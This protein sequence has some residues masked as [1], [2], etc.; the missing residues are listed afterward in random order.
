MA[1]ELDSVNYGFDM[2]QAELIERVSRSEAWDDTYRS[3]T[4]QMLIELYA[5]V[6]NLVLFLIERQ[7]DESYIGT[8]RKKSSIVNLVQLVGYSPKRKKSSTGTLKFTL[9]EASSKKVYIPKDTVVQTNNGIKF[10]VKEDV[11]I[12]PGETE[13]AVTAIQGERSTSIKTATG[14]ANFVV[15]I[16]SQDVEHD[17]IEVTVAGQRWS[18]V[19]FF[20]SSTAQ[21]LHYKETVTPEGVVQ[22]K[23]GGGKF[24]KIPEYGQQVV[25]K[26][27]DSKGID[28][29]V[30]QVGKINTVVSKIQ[31][32]DGQPVNISVMNMDLF[33][34]GD[35]EE[36]VE[37]IR[38][39][40][41]RV[42]KTAD[43]AVSKEDHITFLEGIGGV[44]NA[45]V[46]GEAEQEPPNLAKMNMVSMCVLMQEW[47]SPTADKK[48]EIASFL[49]TRSMETIRYE[50]IP[51]DIVD[52]IVSCDVNANQGYVLSVLEDTVINKLQ[53]LFVLGKTTKLGV[54]K[55]KSN[56]DKV[57]D[58][59]TG[60]GYV[61]LFML[62]KRGL[63]AHYDGDNYGCKL[64]LLAVKKLSLRVYK[65]D[66]LLAKDNGEGTLVSEE[67][68]H[69]AS[70][71]I[72]YESGEIK[73]TLTND[74]EEGSELHVTYE[75]DTSGDLV[76]GRNQILK[77]DQV[78]VTS[79]KYR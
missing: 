4:G 6:A 13:I 36:D 44:A 29:N 18:K 56:I 77:L 2:I 28:G 66:V 53:S 69:V 5:Y 62:I 75:Q 54:N 55:R 49:V 27:I 43:R 60:V 12:M 78:K 14:A 37:E 76:V 64:P 38:E 9:E 33:L 25:I 22:I 23:F 31:D 46:W 21:S 65:D 15:D 30:Y 32:E 8:A 48:K 39:E 40:A 59:I 50:F 1:D 70:G 72:D 11:V 45:N 57:V 51:A 41:P 52:V 3:A 16:P 79:I 19:E 26:Y 10:L 7:A 24:G 74:I 63:Q 67:T 17:S 34:G 71:T 68:D 20:V 61:H 42:T 73:V 35:K 47:L 58:S